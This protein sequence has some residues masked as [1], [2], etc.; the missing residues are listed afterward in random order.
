MSIDTCQKCR[1]RLGTNRNC[2]SCRVYNPNLY[3]PQTSPEPQQP[4]LEST[5]SHSIPPADVAGD[6]WKRSLATLLDSLTLLVNAATEEIK[7]NR[8]IS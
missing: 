5:A 1:H 3:Q 2:I 4:T 8:K 6:T 7:K